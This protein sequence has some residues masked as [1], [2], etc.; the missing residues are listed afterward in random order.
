M[1]QVV[2]AYVDE[3]QEEDEDLDADYVVDEKA[4]HRHPHR[5]TASHKAEQSFNLENLSDPE[6][7]HPRRTTSTR[8]SRP[9]AS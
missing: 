2:V 6:N 8:P 3:K 7:I 9:T 1:K 4:Q 5:T